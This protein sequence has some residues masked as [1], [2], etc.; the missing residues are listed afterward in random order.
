MATIYSPIGSIVKDE[1][2]SLLGQ[3]KGSRTPS[4]DMT[5]CFSANIN[6]CSIEYGEVC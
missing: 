6:E 3:T 1:K 5:L 2:F 4:F